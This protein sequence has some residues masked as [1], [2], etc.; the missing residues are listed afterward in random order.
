MSAV[1]IVFDGAPKA[2]EGFVLPDYSK[3]T[4]APPPATDNASSSTMFRVFMVSD[5]RLGL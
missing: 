4:S 5:E 3:E 2:E 1:L